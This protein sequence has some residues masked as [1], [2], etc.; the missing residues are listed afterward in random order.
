MNLLLAYV[1]N[2][3]FVSNS[4]KLYLH[5]VIFLSITLNKHTKLPNTTCTPFNNIIILYFFFFFCFSICYA[6]RQK[7]TIFI[8]YT[9]NTT[10]KVHNTCTH[11]FF[12]CKN[13]GKITY[14]RRVYKFH[15]SF[16]DSQTYI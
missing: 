13:M 4:F 7:Q 16:S 1:Q 2:H 15:I 6:L 3:F 11:T 10:I 14:S 8:T 12:L 9:F 5:H